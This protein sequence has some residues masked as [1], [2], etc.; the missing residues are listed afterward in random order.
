VGIFV[1][2]LLMN[3]GA[4]GF[5]QDLSEIQYRM[6]ISQQFIDDGEWYRLL[7]AGFIHF[8]LFHVAMNML[9]LYQLGRLLEPAVGSLT[10]GLVYFASLLGGS[11][12][13]LVASPDALTGGASGAV[14][15][16]M[17][18]GVVGLRQRGVNP[19]QTGLGLTFVIN[20][21]FTLAIPGVSIGGHFGGALAGAL[22]G[23]VALAP[24][25]W[26]LPAW[27]ANAAAV[28]VGLLAV[29]IAATPR[30]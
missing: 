30:L 3:I 22:C 16:L 24:A 18:A 10:F 1:W 28:V 27:S 15:G 7:S 17:A 21:L 12:G 20:L 9:L 19:M 8:G 11:A 26:R 6:V 23:S 2:E 4:R 25:R 13:A 29:V 5:S 14:F